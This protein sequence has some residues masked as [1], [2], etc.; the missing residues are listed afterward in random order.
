M[1][2]LTVNRCTISR[3][4]RIELDQRQRMPGVVTQRH[5]GQKGNTIFPIAQAVVLQHPLHWVGKR[6]CHTTL[7]GSICE[8]RIFLP[9]QTML[10]QC[11]AQIG[12][13]SRHSLDQVSIRIGDRRRQRNN[14]FCD[15]MIR[16]YYTI[17][18]FLLATSPAVAY[19]GRAFD[20]LDKFW[21]E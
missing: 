10:P 6:C 14:P 3:Q 11:C 20:S 9:C 2:R 5:T 21:G 15:V 18:A 17:P 19:D 7:T 16:R 8:I 1:G 4:L 12:I 13:G